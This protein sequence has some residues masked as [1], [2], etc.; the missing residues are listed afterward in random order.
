MIARR[1]A[2]RK[3]RAEAERALEQAAADHQRELADRRRGILR[4]GTAAA[5]VVAIIIFVLALVAVHQADLASKERDSAKAHELAAAAD[6]AAQDDPALAERLA[7]NALH[8]GWTPGGENA[9]RAAV[10]VPAPSV[11]LGDPDTGSASCCAAFSRDGRYVVASAGGAARAWDAVSGRQ[12]VDPVDQR[13]GGSVPVV[14]PD[15]QAM[16]VMG[17]KDGLRQVGLTA[18]I[19]ARRFAHS[20][21][22]EFFTPRYSPDGSLIAA[23]SIDG[24]AYVWDAHTGALEHRISSPGEHFLFD[25]RFTGDGRGLVTL[26]FRGVVEERDL[27]SGRVGWRMV[28]A[29]R[30]S[31]ARRSGVAAIVRWDGRVEVRNARDGRG[32]RLL[33][34]R[35]FA[36]DSAIFDSSGRFVAVRGGGGARAGQ[37]IHVWSVAGASLG[38]VS[39]G[40]EVNDFA[41]ARAGRLLATAQAGG[42]VLWDVRTGAPLAHLGASAGA[43]S[44]V[45]FSAD[46]SR[47][48]TSGKDGQVRV[49]D[50]DRVLPHAWQVAGRK[51]IRSAAFSPR[52]DRVAIANADGTVMLATVPDERRITT[53]SVSPGI[54]VR[55]V[56]FSP[57]G[58][59][60]ATASDNGDVTLWNASQG[61]RLLTT[62]AGSHPTSIAFSSDGQAFA[63]SAGWSVRV[64]RTS[65][66]SP[67]RAFHARG[68]VRQ[69]AFGPDG[70]EV[71]AV[72]DDGQVR[73]W[74]RGTGRLVRAL[75]TPHDSGYAIAYSRHGHYLAEGV[76]SGAVIVWDARTGR[77]VKRLVGHTA[78][79]RV[80]RFAADGLHLLS[81]SNDGTARLWDWRPGVGAVVAS[82]IA[83]ATS[84]DMTRDGRWLT[85]AGRRNAA[86]L[87]ACPG[88]AA[89]DDLKRL[90]ERLARPLTPAEAQKYL[91]RGERSHPTPY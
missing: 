33:G 11:T 63:A 5:V 20:D 10:S 28:G 62:S 13:F 56:A 50:V 68:P 1:K 65:N 32:K 90:A 47:L 89:L 66:G 9:L 22:T 21:R 80:V 54:G 39:A 43:A 64:W 8:Y 69:V 72:S 26:G 53:L 83:T 17:A 87:L 27:A 2:E 82:S 52:E 88:C 31:V 4:V 86:F 18:P 25:A 75:R 38:S 29:R 48:V 6:G 36:A 24:S 79:V 67:L 44:S 49:W 16:L 34:T 73:I 78:G 84:V 19:P 74:S 57:N 55:A 37:F 12:V 35:S 46:G 40:A 76:A 3:S 23:P 58:D 14:R 60:L 91:H 7:L 61:R 41:V 81:A 85:V 59:V 51:P 15:S 30:L 42:A 71:A 70:G 77:R 45:A